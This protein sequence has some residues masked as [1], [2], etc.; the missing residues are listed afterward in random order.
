MIQVALAAMVFSGENFSTFSYWYLDSGGKQSHD[1]GSPIFLLFKNTLETLQ[2]KL[3]MEAVSPSLV[4]IRCISLHFILQVL[5]LFLH[6]SLICFPWTTCV[7]SFSCELST[8]PLRRSLGRGKKMET[9]F[10]GNC[11]C[12][13]TGTSF[14]CSLLSVLFQNKSYALYDI[15]V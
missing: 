7:V 5:P 2:F 11:T 10:L 1:N 3:Q 14:F 12:T 6:Y 8:K 4:L 13:C 15:F 9:L